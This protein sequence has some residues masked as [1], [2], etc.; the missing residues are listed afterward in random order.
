MRY[1]HGLWQARENLQDFRRLITSGSNY[2]KSRREKIYSRSAEEDNGHVTICRTG[3]TRPST[4]N[5]LF[6]QQRHY[7]SDTRR[8]RFARPP[9]Q[10]SPSRG[11]RRDRLGKFVRE[12][13]RDD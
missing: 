4:E 11:G 1:R 2:A 8:I 9:L 3:A 12:I 10:Q 7:V 13:I 6:D 5:P